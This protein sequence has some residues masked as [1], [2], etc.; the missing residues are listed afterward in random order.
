MNK[1]LLFSLL[2][3]F[4]CTLSMVAQ[5]RRITGKVVSAGDGSPLPG[6]SVQIKGTS[7]GTSTDA[8]GNYAVSVPAGKSI[9]E[10][11][12]VGFTSQ[13][14]QIGS[15]TIM[16]ITLV[17]SENSLDEVVV[18]GYGTQ[19]KSNLTGNV[20]QIN[21]KAIENLPVV[22]VEQAI[23]GRAAGVFVES[24]NGKV[25]Q[26][27]KMRIRGSSSVSAGNDPLY[28]IDGIP[29]TT[30]PVGS[31]PNTPNPMADI[32][33]N[34]VESIEILKDAS[35]AAIYGARGSNGVVLLTTK[36]GKAGKTNFNLSY[37]TGSSEA[38]G[39]RQFMNT[40]QYVVPESCRDQK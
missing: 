22:S 4:G 25:G 15:Q 38:T 33:F 12:S 16:N 39:H 5:D 20:A 29:M 9:M 23:Q 13:S 17:E 27:I 21:S 14:L 8:T 26:G 28:V 3:F 40:A 24:G 7:K 19:K 32:N 1:H 34:D 2:L 37:F 36:R 35:A 30:T 18:V 11:R 31:S 10:I 6:V